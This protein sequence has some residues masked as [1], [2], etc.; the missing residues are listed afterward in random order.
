MVATEDQRGGVDERARYER[1][2][3]VSLTS[4]LE[5]PGSF[6]PTHGERKW[7]TPSKIKH[8]TP[9]LSFNLLVFPRD[10][11]SSP[12]AL[13]TSTVS[14]LLFPEDKSGTSKAQ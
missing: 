14:T 5:D 8:L 1:V 13:P 11:S 3:Y 10:P 4:A 7:I 9:C 2:G 12:P 6:F